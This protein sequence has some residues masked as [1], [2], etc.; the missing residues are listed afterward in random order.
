[1]PSLKAREL[2]PSGSFSTPHI[3]A[4]QGAQFLIQLLE[5][6]TAATHRRALELGGDD[7]AFVR[8][9][10][11]DAL[12]RQA[13]SEAVQVFCAMT[14]E[15]AVNLLGVLALG[16]ES[17]RVRLERKPHLE[18]LMILLQAIDPTSKPRLELLLAVAKRL[19][20]A[21]NSF[22][23]PKSQEGEFRFSQGAR[24][25][26]IVGAREAMAD[27]RLFFEVLRQCNHRYAVFFNLL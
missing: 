18:K 13:L 16:E 11:D 3:Q 25:S 5:T 7:D 2:P 22:V 19:A 24:R 20:D 17:F 15:G 21:R 12:Q 6:Q 8:A 27:M 26:D 14:V 10:G 1:V 4:F 23:H 9:A